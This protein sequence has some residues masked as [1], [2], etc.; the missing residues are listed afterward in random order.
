MAF[1]LKE[2]QGSMF[3]NL[4]KTEPK[5]PDFRGE[6]KDLS[7]RILEIAG[8]KKKTDGGKKYISLKIQEKRESQG[9]PRAAVQT[10]DDGW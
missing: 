5:H 6:F 7:G 2:G 9:A 8:W 10:Q 1:E 4:K 3:E